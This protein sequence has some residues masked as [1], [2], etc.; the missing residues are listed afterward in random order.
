MAVLVAAKL[1]IPRNDKY[2]CWFSTAVTGAKINEY[3]L[4]KSRVAH[5]NQLEQNFHVFYC[6]LAGLDAERK[7]RLGMENP[8]KFK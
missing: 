4:E 6:M 8:E 7:T 2:Y 3:L 1:Y 5:Q